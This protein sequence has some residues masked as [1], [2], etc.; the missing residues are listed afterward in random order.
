MASGWSNATTF[1]NYHFED[2]GACLRVRVCLVEPK[3]A[4]LFH[5]FERRGSITKVASTATRQ[6]A[7][8]HLNQRNL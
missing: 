2:Q 6:A 7:L 4:T 3:T 1:L 8:A 5:P